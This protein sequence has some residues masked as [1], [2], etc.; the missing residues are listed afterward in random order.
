MLINQWTE[1]V[2]ATNNTNG[3]QVLAYKTS[4]WALNG[5]TVLLLL[6]PWVIFIYYNMP[7]MAPKI[8]RAAKK[9][10]ETKADT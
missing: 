5:M 6:V 8:P 1:R 2:T 7:I 4:V 3:E 10:Q 9:K